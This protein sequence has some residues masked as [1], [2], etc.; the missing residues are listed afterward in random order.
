MG[1]VPLLGV[2]DRRVGAERTGRAKGGWGGL[3]VL[4]G[5]YFRGE[6]FCHT[7]THR[8]FVLMVIE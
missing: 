2:A 8:A 5:V 4:L 7:P 6:F 3:E 1:V